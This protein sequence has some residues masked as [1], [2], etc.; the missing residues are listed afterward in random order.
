MILVAGLGISGAGAFDALARVGAAPA[1]YDD[2][3]IEK[4]E[5][6]LHAKIA[7]AGAGRYLGGR[8][9]PDEAWDYVV[10]SPGV[11]PQLP[12]IER[13]KARGAEVI[14]E[15]ELAFRLGKGMFAAI[16]GT[17][18]KTTTTTLTGE[19]FKAAGLDAVVT[20][21]IG[22]SVAEK[23]VG[24]D[25]DAWLITE[26]SSFQLETTLRFRPKIAALLNLTPDHMDRHRTMEAYAAAKARIFANQGPDDVLVYNADDEMVSSLAGGAASRKLPFSRRAALDAGAFVR[27]GEIVFADGGGGLIAVAY[28]DELK[29]PG[30]HNLENALAAAAISLAAGIGPDVAG[31]VL[32]GFAGVE[33]RLEFVCCTGGVRYVND[34]KGTNPDAAIKAI[35]AVGKGI[36]LIAGGYDKDADFTEYIRA[37]KGRVRKLLLLGATAEKI[38]GCALSEG[39]A[40]GDI[41]MVSCMGEAVRAGA[42]F[43][44]PGDTVLLSP[45]CASWDMYRDYEERGADFK[46]QSLLIQDGGK[47][48]I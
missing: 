2:R 21:N 3:D 27:G 8:P 31:E 42:G 5:P 43:A 26:V 29:I 14:G 32:R 9:V 16:T 10:L 25:E 1:V 41:L 24:V 7:S 23:S 17:N 6:A 38:K 46:A 11:P 48:A 28:A 22:S 39:F 4:D 33:H 30:L 36:V 37:A 13:A 40:E 20:G 34:S 18:G 12:F 19:I 35:E 47:G 45:A 44:A 15:L